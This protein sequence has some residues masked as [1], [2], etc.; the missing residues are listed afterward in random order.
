V[1]TSNFQAYSDLVTFL[2]WFLGQALFWAILSLEF[3]H[4]FMQY[5]I[6]LEGKKKLSEHVLLI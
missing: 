4:E 6:Q 3:H 1:Y 5:H 2:Y